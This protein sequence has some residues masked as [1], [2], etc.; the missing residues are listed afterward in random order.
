MKTI[1]WLA[2]GQRSGSNAVGIAL[3]YCGAE[4]CRRVTPNTSSWNKEYSDDPELLARTSFVTGNHFVAGLP[5][6]EEPINPE[7]WAVKELQSY[8][9]EKFEQ[10]KTHF[11]LKSNVVG[12]LHNLLLSI[13]PNDTKHILISLRR[14]LHDQIN[15]LVARSGNSYEEC[16]EYLRRVELSQQLIE[17][18]FK[19]NNWEILRIKYE[20]VMYN[21]SEVLLPVA[22]VCGLKLTTE[23]INTFDH[24]QWRFRKTND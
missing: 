10:T 16:S 21:P 4:T 23:A 20:E 17:S 2:G 7:E 22:T 24:N 3:Q 19:Q 6:P 12:A 15:S 18:T 14:N 1:I 9:K 8:I 13:F 11:L 5:I